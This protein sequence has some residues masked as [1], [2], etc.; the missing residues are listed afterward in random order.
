MAPAA[1]LLTDSVDYRFAREPHLAFAFLLGALR[2][3]VRR[4][5]EKMERRRADREARTTALVGQHLG[6]RAM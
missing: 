2:G 3:R 5:A 6:C 1:R 4:D